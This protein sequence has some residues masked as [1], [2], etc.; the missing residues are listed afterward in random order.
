M[1]NLRLAVFTGFLFAAALPRAAG[2][3][4]VDD[5]SRV[6]RLWE[7]RRNAIPFVR[8]TIRWEV[9]PLRQKPGDP[10]P[11][12]DGAYTGTAVVILDM[13]NSRLRVDQD[14]LVHF[15]NRP[16]RLSRVRLTLRYDGR[17]QFSASAIDNDATTAPPEPDYETVYI[18][19]WGRNGVGWSL[20][21]NPIL[22]GHGLLGMP[23]GGSYVNVPFAWQV[24]PGRFVPEGNEV[25]GGR[26][27]IVFRDTT[28]PE[29]SVETFWADTE[30][31]GVV[32]RRYESKNG[33]SSQTDMTFQQTRNGWLPSGWTESSTS[34][35]QGPVIARR[36]RVEAVNFDPPAREDEF[37]IVLRR[38]MT[39][40][41]PGQSFTVRADGGLEGID[42]RAA[43]GLGPKSLGGRLARAAAG[44][45]W[46]G[47]V[48]LTVAA[49]LG[50]FLVHL[51]R[52]RAPS[53]V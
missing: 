14:E 7:A 33:I 2:P 31:G 34:P 41:R 29:G 10:K 21:L 3:P 36:T 51:R 45:G 46:V 40:S 16:E 27:C 17:E 43:S 48:G 5:A 30:H 9:F 6:V 32:R 26:R 4:P 15:S 39:V 8:Y 12:E 52:N 37:R 38:G 35:G 28:A 23:R 25:V 19:P 20:E 47:V 1:S 50:G 18:S 44:V 13:P 11:G 53:P 49:L 42:A 24:E 22:W